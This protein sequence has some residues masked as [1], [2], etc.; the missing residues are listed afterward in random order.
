MAGPV[1]QV[2]KLDVVGTSDDAARRSACATM[3]SVSYRPHRNLS[4]P[5]SHSVKT[6]L[7]LYW[8]NLSFGNCHQFAQQL[9]GALMHVAAAAIEPAVAH[10]THRGIE[11]RVAALVFDV[12]LRAVV[13]QKLDHLVI[14][15]L[16]GAVQCRV[17]LQIRCVHIHA[18]GQAQLDGRNDLR[19]GFLRPVVSSS[20]LPSPAAAINGVIPKRVASFGSAPLPAAP[21]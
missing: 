1:L 19:L 3:I 12:Q 2:L 9:G 18:D 14:T 20:L 11:R 8:R 5:S 21:A 4:A 16:R 13:H 15:F 6:P 17:A 7:R 10:E